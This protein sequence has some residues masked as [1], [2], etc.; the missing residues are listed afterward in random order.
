MNLLEP[1]PERPRIDVDLRVCTERRDGELVVKVAL[2]QEECEAVWERLKR[3][4]SHDLPAGARED[5][6]AA[7]GFD[8]DR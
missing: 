6:L 2:D 1:T 5:V 8:V 7:L 4:G 3:E